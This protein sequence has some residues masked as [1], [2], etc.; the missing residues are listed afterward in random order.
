MDKKDICVG[1]IA[2]QGGIEEHI[3][4]VEN[5]GIR[6]RRVLSP[7][8]AEKV[9]HLIIPGG[10]STVI[11]RYMK[12]TGLDQF[13]REQCQKGQIKLWGTCAGAILLG[14]K[15]S[16]YSLGLID[17]DLER[18]AY[19]RQ[20]DSFATTLFVSELKAEVR[21]VFIRAPRITHTGDSVQV[22]ASHEKE[23][24]L[25]RSENILISTFHPE[26]TECSTIH[27]YFFSEF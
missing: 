22:L 17:V 20:I 27:K 11:G 3:G 7:T 14:Q 21:A 13:C 19:G 1:V 25:C 15:A 16:P 8:D 18:N 4:L 2:F 9:T 5:L 6:V 26:L 23:P 10:E 24:V 12:S